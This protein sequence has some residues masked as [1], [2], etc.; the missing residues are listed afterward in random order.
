[1]TRAELQAK[2]PLGSI[3]P[4]L[5][6]IASHLRRAVPFNGQMAAIMDETAATRQLGR[7]EGWLAACES[8]EG[9]HIQAAPPQNKS[10]QAYSEPPRVVPA[11]TEK[12]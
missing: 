4:Q 1:M 7:Y 11:E 2:Y 6:D 5:T 9:I 3:A 10:T 12:K 8:L